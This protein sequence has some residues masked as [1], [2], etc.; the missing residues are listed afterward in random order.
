[1]NDPNRQRVLAHTSFDLGCEQLAVAGADHP[2]LTDLRIATHLVAACAHCDEAGA[3]FILVVTDLNGVAQPWTILT[4]CHHDK[5]VADAQF[6]SLHLSADRR[7]TVQVAAVDKGRQSHQEICIGMRHILCPEALGIVFCDEAG[8]EITRDKPGMRQQSRLERDIAR[9]TTNHKAIERFTHFGN[10]IQAV[11][12]MHDE[13]GNHRVV[14]HGNLAAIL[15]AGVHPDTLPPGH[16]GGEHGFLRRLKAHQ[17]ASGGQEVAKGI[18]G[19]DTAFHRPAI[20]LDIRLC[21]GKLL[22][23]CHPNHEFHQVQPGDAFG[24]RMLHLQAG[25]HFQK[26]KTLVLADDKLHRAGALVLHRLGQCHRLLTHGLARGIA[27]K[28]RRRLFNHLLV[29]ALDRAF[30]LVEV[31]HVAVAV[32]NQLNLDVARFLHELFHKHTVIAETVACLVAATGEA[33]KGLFVVVRHTQALAA[34]SG[35]GLDHHRVPYA[36]GNL[37]RLLG[38]LDRTVDTGDAVHSSRSSQ[39]FGLDLVAHSGHGIVLGADEDNAFL[40]HPF[41][42]LRVFTQ[43]TVAGMQR[44]CA[45]LLAGCNDSV[46]HQIA[47]TRGRWAN[48]YCLISQFHVAGLFVRLGIDGH[49]LDAHLAGGKDD[50]ARNLAT[51]CNQDFGKHRFPNLFSVG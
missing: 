30:T 33:F 37:H 10:R 25:V 20:A 46:C 16:V 48:Q 49:C 38:R 43:K 4:Q 32:S 41:G 24:D 35:A 34:A 5:V 8:I 39:L 47:F 26:V 22:A 45:G 3:C 17:A 29:A 44:L 2:N 36:L 14:V 7:G 31:Q 18:L 6:V 11:L 27:D 28:G 19:I 21:D 13:F 15:H 1:M 23:S 12:A 50:A 40:F 42:K 51:V 9:N